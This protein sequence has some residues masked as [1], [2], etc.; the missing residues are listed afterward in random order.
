MALYQKLVQVA[1]N[2]S[3]RRVTLHMCYRCKLLAIQGGTC[4]TFRNTGCAFQNNSSSR[5][6]VLVGFFREI[7]GVTTT[8]SS[9]SPKVSEGRDDQTF[10]DFELSL[11]V[12]V[13]FL[14]GAGTGAL[15]KT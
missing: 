12:G 5:E 15:I 14:R 11:L 4:T 1:A 13:V 10:V 7:F 3:R 2:I 6:A 8:S 9:S